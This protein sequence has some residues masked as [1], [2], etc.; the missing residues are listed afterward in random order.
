MFFYNKSLVIETIDL[1]TPKKNRGR[2]EI[3]WPKENGT[4][5]QT[6]VYKMIHRKTKIEQDEPY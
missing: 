1:L 6:R 5:G 4:T 3:Q 2:K